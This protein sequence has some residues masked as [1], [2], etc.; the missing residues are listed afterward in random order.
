MQH[1]RFWLSIDSGAGTHFSAA[2]GRSAKE[3]EITRRLGGLDTPLG[4]LRAPTDDSQ[5]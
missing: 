5:A 4:R 3:E 1:I 2:V